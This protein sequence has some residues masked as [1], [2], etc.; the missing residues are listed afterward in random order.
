[1]NLLFKCKPTVTNLHLGL[2]ASEVE[3]GSYN[4]TFADIEENFTK[5]KSY[6]SDTALR[7]AECFHA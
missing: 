6:T 2:K 3:N 7:K 5:F 4:S 1:M